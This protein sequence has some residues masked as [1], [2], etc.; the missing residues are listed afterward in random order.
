M[1]PERPILNS[2]LALEKLRHLVREHREDVEW[3]LPPE[4]EL[5]RFIGVGRR[6]VRR[7]MEVVEAE[8][9]VWRQ[10]GKGT[11]VG[12]RPAIQPQLVG[13]IAGR[14]NPLEVMEARLQMEPALARMAA[15]RCSA[16]DIAAL[17]R[18]AQKTSAALDDDGWELWDSAFHRRIAECAGNG[19][20]LSLFDVVQRI[21][22]E[23]VWRL[24]RAKTRNGDRRTLSVREH[25]EIVAAIA[26][27]D[28][29]GAERAMRRHLN[30]INANLQSRV[31]G[32]D[33]D[34]NEPAEVTVTS[35]KQIR[36]S[37]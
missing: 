30:A 26:G 22:Q 20:L 3:Q 1:L 2:L 23:P 28:G 32:S 11:F 33:D 17:E 12:R 31:V 13:N 8:G 36:T 10:Q 7:A 15:M 34:E 14:T 9:L 4:R 25:E 29:A 27:R 35:G 5:A 19:L 18:L 37:A 24:L 16:D 6:A 21:R